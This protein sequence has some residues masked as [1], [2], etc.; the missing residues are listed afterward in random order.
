MQSL[1][2][3]NR[4]A[5]V[6]GFFWLLFCVYLLFVCLFLILFSSLNTRLTVSASAFFLPVVA[7]ETVSKLLLLWAFFLLFYYFNIAHLSD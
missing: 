1:I 7:I 6:V 5:E 4:E 3:Q 2:V